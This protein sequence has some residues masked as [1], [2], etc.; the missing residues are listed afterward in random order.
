MPTLLKLRRELYE[1]ET[2]SDAGAA[3]LRAVPRWLPWVGTCACAAAYIASIRVRLFIAKW[4]RAARRRAERKYKALGYLHT[5]ALPPGESFTLAE[6]DH[7]GGAG[8]GDECSSSSRSSSSSADDTALSVADIEEFRCSL[9]IRSPRDEDL[10]VMVEEMLLI[11]PIPDGW[12]LYRTTSG[13]VRFMNLNTQ[14]LF[15]FHPCKREEERY[16][17]AEVRHRNRV[18]MESKYNFSYG[19]EESDRRTA[20]NA[21]LTLQRR[22]KKMTSSRDNGTPNY[23]ANG[24]NASLRFS[25]DENSEGDRD[26]QSTF[27]R[28]FH[29]FVEREQRKIERDVEKKYRQSSVGGSNDVGTPQTEGR[30]LRVLPANVVHINSHT[31]RDGGS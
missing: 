5:G 31:K 2:A 1:A 20:A 30:S 19:D 6:D 3:L 7:D 28:L 25:D 12:V 26:E 23:K 18:T 22:R 4:R 14:E 8:A 16:I 17:R 21:S 15:F 29:Y 10:L 13:V 9:G 24:N 11:D 27:R